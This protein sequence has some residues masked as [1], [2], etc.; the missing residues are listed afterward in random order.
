M[1]RTRLYRVLPGRVKVLDPSLVI[2]G[3]G[4]AIDSGKLNNLQARWLTLL[5]IIFSKHR[6]IYRQ[7]CM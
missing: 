6:E 5:G 1:G 2:F 7:L 4:H 3:P